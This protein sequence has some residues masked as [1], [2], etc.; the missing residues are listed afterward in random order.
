MERALQVTSMSEVQSPTRSWESLYHAV[1][2]RLF[3][4][5][6]R[7]TGDAD[8][9]A[10]IVHDTFL[11]VAERIGQYRGRGDLETWVCSIGRNLAL[12][13]LR[14]RRV[15]GH[16]VDPATAHH[17]PRLMNRAPDTELKVVVHDAVAQLPEEL[18]SVLLLYEVD[19]FTHTEI[20]KM[21]D[22]AEG[23]SRAR[24]SRARA[25]LREWLQHKL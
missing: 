15:R 9:A 8:T 6:H 1:G 20:A 21:L 5:A 7:I 23:S 25:R 11:R 17:E 14:K 19:G 24:L 16:Q 10:D 12:E 13:H 2:E 18:R 4:L 22:I 3:R